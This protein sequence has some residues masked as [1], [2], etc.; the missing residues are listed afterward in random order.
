[1][2]AN[3]IKTSSIGNSNK[4]KEILEMMTL[5]A[6]ETLSENDVTV[7]IEPHKDF[8]TDTMKIGVKKDIDREYTY[9]IIPKELV[10]GLLYQTKHR[11]MSGTDIEIKTHKAMTLYFIFHE[12]YDG[13]YTNI[14][15]NLDGWEICDTAPQYDIN[16][17][18]TH[19]AGH[20]DNQKM[21]KLKAKKNTTYSIPKS[22]DSKNGATWCTWN[23]VMVK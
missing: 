13:N 8:Y 22:D 5:E 2:S 1:M 20:G 3:G 15:K 18:N 16:T 4:T 7:R 11:I 14:F 10:G 21:Y 6:K 9:D 17:R 19:M 12:D 23:I